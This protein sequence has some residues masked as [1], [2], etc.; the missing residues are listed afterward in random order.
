MNV[1]CKITREIFNNPSNN[2]RVLACMLTGE[3]NPEIELNQYG[4]FTIAGS[5]LFNLDINEEY[6]LAIR[7]DRNAKRP[8]SYKMVGFYGVEEGK[9]ITVSREREYSI[10]S[11]FMEDSQVH[12]VLDAYP[13]FCQMILDGRESE[14]DYKN[15]YNVGPVRYESYVNAVKSHFQAIYFLPVASEWGVEDWE[16]IEKLIKVYATPDDLREAFT[17][18]PYHVYRNDLGFSF[19]RTD[20]T[21]L[22]KKPEFIDSYERCEFGCLEIFK[23]MEDCGDT[24]VDA[25]LMKEMA[26]ELVPESAEHLDDVVKT[27]KYIYYDPDTGYSSLKNTYDYEVNICNAIMERVNAPKEDSYTPMDWHDFTSVDGLNCTEEQ[28]NF[29]KLICSEH[30]S[31]L[32]GYAGTGKST[33]QKAVILMLEHYNKSYVLL[34][35]T[36]KAAARLRETTGRDAYTIH[37][38]LARIEQMTT[39]DYIIIDEASMVGVEL[40]SRLMSNICIWTNLVFICDEAQLAS[41]SCGNVIQDLIDSGKVKMSQLTKVFRYGSSGLA[42]IAT[43]TRNGELGPRTASNQFLDYKF[44]S[45]DDDISNTEVLKKVLTVYE[46][47]INKGYKQ[48]DILVLCPFNKTKVG[49][50]AINNAIQAKFNTHESKTMSRVISSEDTTI[51]FK[52]G[53]KVINTVN[54]YRMETFTDCDEG[55]VPSEKI[56][57][58]MNGD[59]GY[60]RWVGDEDMAV[61]FDTGLAHITRS[62]VRNLLLGYCITVHKSQGSQAK[63]VIFISTKMHRKMLTRNLLYVADTR[64]Q[65]ELIEIGQNIYIEEA[66]GVVEQNDRD[67]WLKDLMAEWKSEN[68]QNSIEEEK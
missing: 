32:R 12:Y 42:T 31:M 27:S 47:L 10:L 5:N 30:V 46:D 1:H 54:N 63:A 3:E 38:Y 16:Q 67:T 20:R 50:Y 33:V 58:V 21:V 11:K 39:P 41:I 40:M 4:N 49:T 34:A 37:M 17:Q 7:E 64:A 19:K 6:D 44:I 55:L 14:I 57:P 22:S 2:F 56:I 52:V 29:L 48:D 28:I 66:L 9:K 24:R 53:D 25:D 36:G 8:A 15:I 59:I 23:E 18:N 51:E 35:P 45:I 61:Q 43:D 62:T 60:V 68:N 26:S 13:D 65:E